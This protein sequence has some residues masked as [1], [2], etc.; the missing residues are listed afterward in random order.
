MPAAW[1]SL[2][3]KNKHPR[4]ACI[5]FDEPTHIYTVNGTYEG[6]ISCTG[7]LHAFFGH[8]DAAATVKKMRA[9]PKWP[10]SKYYGMTDEAIIKLWSDSGAA[11]SEAGTAMHLAIEQF[12][13]DAHAEIVP[14]VTQTKEWDYFMDFWREHGDDLEP[15]RTEW[16]VWAEEIKLA[17]SI[18]MIFRRKSTGEY[19]VY[20]WK[21]S[22]EIKTD[23]KFQQGLG[24]L[25]H[26]PDCN[27]WHYALQLNVYRWMLQTHYGLKITELAIL[28]FHP[29]NKGYKRYKLPLMEDEVE[30]MIECR[31][32]AVAR[33]NCGKNGDPVELGACGG[34]A[35]EVEEPIEER[36]FLFNFGG[37]V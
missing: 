12:L 36:G 13:N 14:A 28:V 29:E 32:A 34:V 11:A 7:F 22:R 21:R 1:Q 23:N 10:Q 31:R 19:L 17:G 3:F 25:S 9:S 2:A 30:M 4:D 8:F 18:D 35:A 5:V 37:K 24:P 15:F 33:G 20:D 6:Y 26:L 16:E 27:Y